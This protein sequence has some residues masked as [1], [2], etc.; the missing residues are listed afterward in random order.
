MSGLRPSSPGRKSG[1]KC[2]SRAPWRGTSRPIART[3]RSTAAPARR[4]RG[5]AWPARLAT[6]PA[7]QMVNMAAAYARPPCEN[8]A[9]FK[10]AWRVASGR[11]ASGG[12][13]GISFALLMLGVLAVLALLADAF[14]AARALAPFPARSARS[15]RWP[16][17]WSTDRW[18]QSR[19]APQISLAAAADQPLIGGDQR[20]VGIDEHPAVTGR[21][22]HVE[23]QVIAGAAFRL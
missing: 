6:T 21:H 20:H 23:V 4:L 17:R 18:W 11:N 2:A 16:R 8:K 5:A 3:A 13:C 1:P 9:K 22:L 7:I 10:C 14:A 19:P 12:R 15:M